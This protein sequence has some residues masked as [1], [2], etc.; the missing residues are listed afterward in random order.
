[1]HIRGQLIAYAVAQF[2]HQYR[3]H[4]FSVLIHGKEARLL[5]W[6][7]AGA[8]V[9][10]AFRYDQQPHLANFYS[11]YI[12]ATPEARGID[13]TVVICDD[14]NAARARQELEIKA[15]EPLFAFKVWN[16]TEK[17]LDDESKSKD[18]RGQEETIEKQDIPEE[19]DNGPIAYYGGEPIFSATQSIT[20]RA[21]R[22]HCPLEDR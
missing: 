16:D 1:M 7:H 2:T 11:R 19:A 9:T 22:E 21:T 14:A 17:D 8:V 3:T 6:D 4:I 12:N 13:S 10:K 15:G 18:I 20:G 5:R